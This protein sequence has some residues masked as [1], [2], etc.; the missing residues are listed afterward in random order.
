MRT[1]RLH[2]IVLFGSLITAMLA[3][4]LLANASIPPVPSSAQLSGTPSLQATTAIT[5]DTTT[6]MATTVIPRTQTSV[7][8]ALIQ[9]PVIS[10]LAAG[11]TFDIS[12]IHMLDADQGWGIGGTAQAQ[13]HVFR[14][15]TGGKTW[16]DVT[17]PQPAPAA[18]VSVVALGYFSDS[19]NGWVVY[20]PSDSSPV[21]SYILVWFTHDGGASWT[22]GKIDATGVS[23]ESFS[24]WY[25]D[26]S[27]SQ[28]G[29]LMVYLGA[30]MMHAYVALYSTNDGGATWKDIL[31]PHMQNDIQSF[32]KTGMIFVDADTGWLTR[33]AQGVEASPHIFKTQDGGLN[34]TRIDLPAPAGAA[35]WFD[36]NACGTYSPFAFSSQSVYLISKCLDNAT[37]KVE[38]DFLYAT[39][40]GGQ[41]WK[42]VALPSAFTVTGPPNGGLFFADLQNGLA[43]SRWIYRTDDGGKTWSSGK[44][45]NWDG[46]FSFIDLNTGW[47]VATNAGQIALVSTVDGGKTWQE[48]QPVVAP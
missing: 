41:T 37:Y 32:T 44:Q 23:D 48:I 14:T 34:W 6:P 30:G 36:N 8:S 47:A 17:P 39:E 5:A 18:G 45:V 29:W 12:Y 26:F 16:R 21:P 15:G 40:D 28:H 4:N 10:H 35:S 19:S 42:S 22:S 33:D 31:D 20:G 1:S 27:D 25:L 13:D 7:P 46:Q 9:A 11:Q 2:Q 24:P 3:C 38:H 43:L